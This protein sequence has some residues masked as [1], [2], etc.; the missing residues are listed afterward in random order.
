[1]INKV[2]EFFRSTYETA[3]KR[4]RSEELFFGLT[5]VST[6]MMD[7]GS[8]V[9]AV[10]SLCLMAFYYFF[11]GWMMLTTIQ[12]KH[13]F[14]SIVSGIGYSTGLLC[15]A[16]VI[17][18]PSSNYA[19]FYILQILILVSIGY[20]LSKQANWGYYKT[21]HYVRIAIFLFLDVY[22]LIFK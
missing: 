21:N 9:P 12:E 18:L 13:I 14:F 15:M 10:V 22:I 7:Y 4:F 11:F 19:F 16:L 6:V 1:M 17:I 20:Y 2:I 8:T 3:I 5:T